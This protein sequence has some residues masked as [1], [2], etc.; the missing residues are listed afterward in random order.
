[1]ITLM[2]TEM[3][4]NEIRKALATA[5]QNHRSHGFKALENLVSDLRSKL[6]DAMLDAMD[7]IV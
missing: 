6:N 1:M 7:M 3:E 2:V 4:L 5:E